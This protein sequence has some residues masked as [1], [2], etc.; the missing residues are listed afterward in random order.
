MSREKRLRWLFAVF[1][2]L[3]LF[4][5]LDYFYHRDRIYAGVFVD[6]L[7]VGGKKS[8]EAA[9]LL[10]EKFRREQ[11]A[12]REISLIFQENEWS[13]SFFELGI[14]PD[15]EAT[16]TEAHAVGREEY[17]FLSY[18]QRI[19]LR[20]KAVNLMPNFTVDSGLFPLALAEAAE[21]IRQEP[22]DATF[23]LTADRKMVE[24]IPDKIGRELDLPATLAA[25]EQALENYSEIKSLYLA[26][27]PVIAAITAA[28]LESLN[29]REPIATFS[30]TFTAEDANR[31][32]NILLAAKAIDRK[33]VFSGGQFSFNEVVGK[34]TS[35]RGYREAPVIVG[36][37]LVEGIGGGICQVSSTLYNT[38]LLAD[39]SILERRNHGLAVA[40]L[41]PGRD[42]TIS[43]G[44]IDLR[45]LNDRN[46]AVWLR[47]F[48][49]GNK[50]TVTFYGKVIPG[51]EVL[52]L[53][54]DLVS[55]EAQEEIIM[56]AELPKGVREQLRRGQS[57]Y[58]VT[59][60]RVKKMNGK[61]IS[62]EML[63]Q[64]SYRSVPYKYRVGT[65]Q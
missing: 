31:N 41:P 22:Q 11:L 28:Y 42:A 20:G 43:Y 17:H 36:G 23:S 9:E 60:W 25:L 37:E 33:L 8:D 57:G 1:G 21:V 5:M 34:A 30:T 10:R 50:L 14:A 54:T 65:A 45:F 24:I 64:D 59:V 7:N 48:V 51:H 16:I 3:L 47:T 40:Y 18:L 4:S 63:S 53:T 27:T 56:T 29:V 35:Q 61:E 2:I 15:I 55:I 46:H 39:L 62:R 52:I 32:H 49:D 26:E 44:W 6:G 38:I 58:R 13:A 12:H 19:S